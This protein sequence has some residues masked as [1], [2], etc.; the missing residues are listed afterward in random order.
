[1]KLSLMLTLMLF[2]WG[3]VAVDIMGM[4]MLVTISSVGLAMMPA[5]TGVGLVTTSMVWPCGLGMF[6]STNHAAGGRS[7]CSGSPED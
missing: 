3:S 1:M 5:W 6:R 7:R 4:I 2:I